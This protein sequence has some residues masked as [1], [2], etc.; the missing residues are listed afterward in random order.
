MMSYKQAAEYVEANAKRTWAI[1]G[2]VFGVKWPTVRKYALTL[3]CLV[4][5]KRVYSDKDETGKR[6]CFYTVG[7]G[8][9]FAVEGNANEAE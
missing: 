6:F 5:K 9:A 8:V 4:G 7:Q 3:G 2:W 1:N